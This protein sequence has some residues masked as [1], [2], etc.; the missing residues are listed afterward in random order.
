MQFHGGMSVDEPNRLLF[1]A[2]PNSKAV[3]VVD[4]DTLA[5]VA[6]IPVGA[7]PY[8]VAVDPQRR[9]GVTS[10]QGS[11][12][13]NATAV[14]RLQRR[15]PGGERLLVRGCLDRKPDAS[16]AHFYQS[17]A[18]GVTAGAERARPAV[19]IRACRE[20]GPFRPARHP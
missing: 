10:N 2:L 13:E 12:A 14:P 18:L 9:V 1:A 11:P 20:G 3:G 15:G 6:T 19:R 16:Q 5:H 4:L 17:A 8:A 7:C